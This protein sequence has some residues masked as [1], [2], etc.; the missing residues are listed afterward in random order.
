MAHS[1]S[2]LRNL[3]TVLAACS[4]DLTPKGFEQHGVFSLLHALRVGDHAVVRSIR[5]GTQDIIWHHGVYVGDEHIVHMH[6]EGNISKVPFETFMGTITR[7]VCVDTAGVV[8]YTSDTAVTRLACAM[9]ALLATVDENMQDIEYS[10]EKYQCDGFAAWCRTGRCE[11]CRHI[12][13]Q[14]LCM[15]RH[16]IQKV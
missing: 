12:L 9:R 15:K 16:T 14:V 3:Q 7:G 8:S 2:S 5:S 4:V 1:T 11:S 10:P 13:S 6:P